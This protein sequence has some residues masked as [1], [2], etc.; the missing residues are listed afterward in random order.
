MSRFSGKLLE[1]DARQELV[2]GVEGQKK[3]TYTNVY[4]RDPTLRKE[5]MRI[6]GLDC[7]ACGFNFEKFYGDHGAG[8]IHVHHVNPISRAGGPVEIVPAA[9]LVPL[10]ANCHAMVH[11]RKDKTVSVPELVAMIQSS[12]S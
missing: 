12:G 9:D 10:C 6:H 5:A 1:E 8:F 3:Q 2:S 11:R 4:E 7:A